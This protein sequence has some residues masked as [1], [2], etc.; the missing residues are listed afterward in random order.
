M[1]LTQEYFD[2]GIASLMEKMATKEDLAS[3]KVELIT[4]MAT[5]EDLKAQGQE[6]KQ[7]VHE[8]FEHHQDW[9]EERLKEF[10]ITYDVRD[11]VK[12]LER[13]VAQLKLTN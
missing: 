13:D 1:E 5:K 2:K 8:A 4:K 7:Y 9:T 12:K 6:L 10:A 11:R 3:L